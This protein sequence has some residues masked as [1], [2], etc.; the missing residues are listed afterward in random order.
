MNEIATRN[1]NALAGTQGE[2]LP[3]A[4]EAAIVR[5]DLASLSIPQRIQWYRRRCE[6]AGLNPVSRPFE[7][8]TLQGKLTLYATKSCTDQLSGI[9]GL[10]H[11]IV[12]RETTGDIHIVTAEVSNKSGRSTQDIGAVV[13]SAL[14]GEALCNAYMKAITKAK[15]RAT[16]SL[17]GLGDVIDEAELD[18]VRDARRIAESEV[19]DARDSHHAKNHDNATGHGIGAYARPEDVKAFEAWTRD[20]VDA[21][22]AKWLDRHTGDGG[23]VDDGVKDLL[24][25]FQL[26]GHLY[27]WARAEGLVNAPEEVRSGQRDKFTAVAWLRDR[28]EIEAE[29]LRYGREKWREGLARL[30]ATSNPAD[31]PLDGL[32]EDNYIREP[33]DDDE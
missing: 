33:G 15:R 1:G 13:I 27:K 12:S 30:A 14:R 17:C 23:L 22:N 6:A 10:S 31:D 24:S 20:Q 19:V 32:T 21:I 3:E 26:A 28:D 7:Y 25:T 8:I 11:R 2:P 4:I 18:T 16:L 9:H 29:A 5:G